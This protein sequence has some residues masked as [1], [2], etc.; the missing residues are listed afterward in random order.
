MVVSCLFA[1]LPSIH[2]CPLVSVGDCFQE[3]PRDSPPGNQNPWILKSLLQRLSTVGPPYLGVLGT[4]SSLMK[5]LF[6]YFSHFKVLFL[7]TKFWEF[8]IY[9]GYKSFIRCVLLSFSL[10]CLFLFLTVSF[11]EP[12]SLILM[13]SV[14][15]FYLLWI[16][17]LVS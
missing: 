10:T 4:V 14:Y 2:S 3:T 7:I 8:L 11:D 16:M 6:K 9:S 12:K 13:M 17:L 15:Q 5:D 1:Y